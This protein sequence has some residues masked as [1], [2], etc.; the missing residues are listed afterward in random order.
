[1]KTANVAELKNRLSDYLR[2]VEDGE[3]VE[4]A[5]Q[6]RALCPHRTALKI[7]GNG[8]QLGCLKGSVVF[9]GDLTTPA[10]SEE[11]WDMLESNG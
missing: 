9:D 8:T 11:D 4:V 1:M 3:T 5:K 7:P 2:L 10:M 6:K